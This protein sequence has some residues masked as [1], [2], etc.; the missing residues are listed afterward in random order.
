[1]KDIKVI[2][3]GG[4][5]PSGKRSGATYMVGKARLEAWK[6]SGKFEMDIEMPKAKSKAKPKESKKT[7]S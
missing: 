5:A 4:N 7:K 2:F 3:K 6:K 1:M